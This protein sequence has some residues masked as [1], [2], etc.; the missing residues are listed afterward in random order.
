[1]LNSFRKALVILLC[2]VLFGGVIGC[3]PEEEEVV[4]DEVLEK[5]NIVFWAA[6][7]AAQFALWGRLGEDF[8]EAQDKIYVEVGQMPEMP[9]SEAGILNALILDA[10]P[11]LSENISRGFA[12]Q[13]AGDAAIINLAEHE[14]FRDLVAMRNMAKTIKGWEFAGG[15]QYVLPLYSNSMLNIWRIDIL[16]ELGF[17]EIPATYEEIYQVARVLAERDDLETE[18]VYATNFLSPNWWDRWFDFLKYYNHASQGAPF[19]VGGELVANDQAA[20]EVLTHFYTLST[21]EAGLVM[22]AIDPVQTGLAL[23]S[24]FGPW[25]IGPLQEEFPEL[26]F[27]EHWDFALPPAPREGMEPKTFADTKGISIYAHASEEEID[28]AFTFIYWVFAEGCGDLR[29]METTKMPPA[30]DDAGT[31]EEF[32]GFFEQNPALKR[33]AAA[34]PYGI[35]AMAHPRMVDIQIAMGDYG[36]IPMMMGELSPEEAWEAMKLAIEEILEEER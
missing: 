15:H 8:N 17:D 31:K 26:V 19:I 36:Q 30:R 21:I 7:D 2:V 22:G 16:E 11:T 14:K 18:F 5:V 10:A 27:G 32:V 6:P 13:L 4:A 1:M 35:P 23:T 3:A 9:S 12:A 25:G 24:G 20:I 28:A 34:I 33:Y 29:W